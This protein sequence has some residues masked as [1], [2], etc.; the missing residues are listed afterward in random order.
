MGLT[1]EINLEKGHSMSGK[2]PDISIIIVNYKVKDYIVLLLKSIKK[3]QGGLAIEIFVV[4]NNSEDDSVEYLSSRFSDV[5][6]IINNVNEGFG[7]A[8]NQ[9]LKLASGDLT[10]IINPDTVIEENSLSR[11]KNFMDNNQCCGAAGYRMINFDGAFARECRRSIPDLKSAFFRVLFLDSLFPKHKRIGKR[12]LGWRSE[13]EGHKVD[14]ISGAGMFWRTSVLKELGGFDEDFFMY[15]EDDDL[16]YRIQSTPHHIAYIPSALL[17]H[18]KGESGRKLSLKYFQ[19]INEGLLLFFKKHVSENYTFVFRKII[20]LGYYT[21]V[22][23]IYLS[24]IFSKSISSSKKLKSSIIIVSS[25]KPSVEIWEKLGEI[26]A[27][28]LQW[29]SVDPKEELSDRIRS[30]QDSSRAEIKVVFDIESIS[31]ESIFEIMENLKGAKINF[32]FFDPK[33]NKI[34]GKASVIEL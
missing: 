21:R 10:L 18:F 33:E 13:F 25:K 19:K 28:E 17:L 32:Q 14:V 23:I 20:S 8:N 34:V 16:C 30:I 11:L 27:E 22:L 1:K 4:D 31:F 24:L 15:G 29:I 9:A 7:T 3:A 2:P 12:Y 26:S 5:K 6:F